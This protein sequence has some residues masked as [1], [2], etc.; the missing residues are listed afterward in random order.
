VFVAVGVAVSVGVSVGVGVS[1]GVSVGIGVGVCVSVGVAVGTGV[2]VSVAVGTGVGVS[3][4]ASGVSVGVAVFVGVGVAVGAWLATE[5]SRQLAPGSVSTGL[6]LASWK[7]NASAMRARKWVSG[8]DPAPVMVKGIV[9]IT[10]SPS[11]PVAK[12]EQAM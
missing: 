11:G 2:L 6:Q 10:T 7:A 5:P 8:D 4:G 1:T 9:A 3:V 12:I